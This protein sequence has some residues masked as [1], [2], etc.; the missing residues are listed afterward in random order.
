M[1]V[2][3][4]GECSLCSGELVSR[5]ELD[6]GARGEEGEVGACEGGEGAE[7]SEFTGG[8]DGAGERAYKEAPDELSLLPHVRGS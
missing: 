3:V 2:A 7:R 4:G 5:P 8:E 6:G 1:A